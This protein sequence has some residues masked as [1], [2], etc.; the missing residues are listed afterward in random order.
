MRHASDAHALSRSAT[1][2]LLHACTCSIRRE[3]VPSL[4]VST[5]STGFA[6]A[7]IQHHDDRLYR[8]VLVRSI[9]PGSLGKTSRTCTCRVAMH[10]H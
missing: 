10:M 3:S 2:L 4:V 1:Q 5:T 7:H 6:N 9:R 8:Y